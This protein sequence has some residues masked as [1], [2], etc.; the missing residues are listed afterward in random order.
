MSPT[1][2]TVMVIPMPFRACASAFVFG[3]LRL[4][5]LLVPLSLAAMFVGS[6]AAIYQTDLKRLLAYSSVAQ[7]GYMTLGLSMANATGLT[8][9]LLHLFNHALMKGG[10]FLVAA[11]VVFRVGSSTISDLRGLAHRMPLTAAAFVVGGLSLVGV[12]G[13]VGFISKWYLVLGA[14]ERNSYFVAFLILMSSLLAAVYVWRVV[15]VMISQAPDKDEVR[16]DAPVPML[17]PTWILIGATVFF[18]LHAEWSVSVASTAAN[19]LFGGA[20]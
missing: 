8:G 6:L 4:H 16:A 2:M 7:I 9:G 10:L 3:T 17:F 20:R 19:Q 15:E 18:G 5:F 13:T 1:S 11:C 14:L 12:P